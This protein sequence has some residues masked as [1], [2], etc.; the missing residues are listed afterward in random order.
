[1]IKL[2][3]CGFTILLY[4]VPYIDVPTLPDTSKVKDSEINAMFEKSGEEAK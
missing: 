3:V 2:D 1:M 4:E